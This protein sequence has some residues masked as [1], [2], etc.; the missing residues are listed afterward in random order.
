[1]H[2]MIAL[3]AE[4]VA[5]AVAMMTDEDKAAL[6]R[7]VTTFS[8]ALAALTDCRFQQGDNRAPRHVNITH[9]EQPPQ[10]AFP[11]GRIDAVPL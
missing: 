10:L 4:E 1:M 8:K 3:T 5:S 7:V 9:R 11:H 6:D 2:G